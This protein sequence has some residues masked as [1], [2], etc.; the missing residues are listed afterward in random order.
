MH[1]LSYP[2]MY[3]CIMLKMCATIVSF[4][5]PDKVNEVDL[6]C[7]PVNLIVECNAEWEV[8][9]YVMCIHNMYVRSYIR[10]YIHS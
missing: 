10:M 3:V 1:M 7:Y 6:F 2:C 4:I 8:S 9:M 5:V